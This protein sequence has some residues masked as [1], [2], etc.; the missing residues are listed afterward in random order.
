MSDLQPRVDRLRPELREERAEDAAILERAEGS[1]VE[2]RD[3][4]GKHADEVA[5]ADTEPGQHVREAARLTPERGEGEI[6]HLAV[7]AEPAQGEML[8][9]GSRRVTVDGLVRDVQSPS[10]GKAVEGFPRPLPEVGRTCRLVVLKV[11]ND[12]DRVVCLDDRGEHHVNSSPDE[13]GRS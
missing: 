11:R 7:L 3:A 5:L 2:L 8:R 10:A 13:G 12:L 6:A 1:D 4:P 9:S